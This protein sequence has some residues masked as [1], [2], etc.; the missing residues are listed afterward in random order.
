M[1]ASIHRI[2]TW[3]SLPSN[4]HHP[5]KILPYQSQSSMDLSW[6]LKGSIL[7]SGINSERIPFLQNTLTISQKHGP[8][9]PMVCFAILVLS[10][11]QTPRTFGFMSSNIHMITPLQDILV[12]QRHYTKSG[13]TTTC[14]D[15]PF[16]SRTTAD[17]VLTVPTPNPCTTNL[18]DFSSNFR[19]PRSLGIP[20]PWISQR[21]SPL[22]QVIPQSQLLLIVFKAVIVYSNS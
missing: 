15:F 9:T 21:S 8:W 4:L 2:T 1:P 6:I 5:S 19:S 22:L 14:Q 3:Y 13:N 12:K 17:C 11:S 20:S 10:M 7:T 16:M 18:M